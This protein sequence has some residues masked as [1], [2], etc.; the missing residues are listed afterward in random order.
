MLIN[1]KGEDSLCR[2]HILSTSLASLV[3][4]CAPLANYL[5][6]CDNNNRR[7]LLVT[8]SGS[9]RASVLCVW[10]GAFDAET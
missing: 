2:I 6:M 10:N 4:P 3:S 9:V 7:A 1:T 5:S 8:T